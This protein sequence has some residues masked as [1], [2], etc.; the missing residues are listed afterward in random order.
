MKISQIIITTTSLFLMINFQKPPERTLIWSDEFEGTELNLEHWNF[1]L[2]NGCPELCG[3]GNNELQ[4]YTD[5][6]HRVENGMLTIKTTYENSVYASTRI[7]SQN[8]KSFQYGYIETRAKLPVGEGIWPAFWL[9]GNNIKE[10]G[11]P[12][13]GEID[14][15]EYA[16]KE[17]EIIHT[18]LHTKD[19]HGKTINTRKTKV[20]KVEEGFHLYAVDWTAEKMDFYI[21]NK[22]VYTFNPTDKTEETWPFEQPFY[23]LFNTAVGGNFGGPKV[24]PSIFPQEF[25][26]DYVRVYENK[27]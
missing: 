11:W 14:V 5:K 15:L 16:G 1:V 19:S 22:L 26:I 18:S 3:F 8:K 7:H 17:P 21:D 4:V 25:V 20:N 24:D 13:C 9:L 2:G 6:N 27:K 12:L 23:I 10:V